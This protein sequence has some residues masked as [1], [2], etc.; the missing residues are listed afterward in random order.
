VKW[1]LKNVLHF[2]N[3]TNTLQFLVYNATCVLALPDK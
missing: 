2:Y 3:S 1:E